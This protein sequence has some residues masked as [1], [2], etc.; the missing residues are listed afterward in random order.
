MKHI[1]GNSPKC[2]ECKFYRER[3]PGDNIRYDGWC[4]NYF[5]NNYLT[6]GVKLKEPTQKRGVLW[7]NSCDQWKGCDADG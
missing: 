7:N 4:V 1:M 6:K 3:E 5:N 2:S